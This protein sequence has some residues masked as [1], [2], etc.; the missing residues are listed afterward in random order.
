MAVDETRVAVYQGHE[1]TR[2]RLD[3]C[4]WR[5]SSKS[6]PLCGECA[7]VL[8]VYLFCL[9]WLGLRA[10]ALQPDGVLLPKWFC[11]RGG[12]TARGWVQLGA[13]VQELSR[14]ELL[15]FSLVQGSA[16]SSEHWQTL[17]VPEG[18][19]PGSKLA[20]RNAELRNLWDIWIPALTWSHP[21]P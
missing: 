7:E 8:F 1:I 14:Q 5:S 11:F 13:F 17:V 18:F 15:L 9:V 10:S 3:P 4:D 2:E 16:Q 21:Q 20:G 6:S 19:C 12:R